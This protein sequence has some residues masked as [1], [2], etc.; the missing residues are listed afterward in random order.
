MVEQFLSFVTE[1]DD[2][3]KTERRLIPLNTFG[4]T[5]SKFAIK[6]GTFEIDENGIIDID[7]VQSHG[8]LTISPD[9]TKVK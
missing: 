5:P 8:K 9:G 4:L 7:F 1:E 2:V 3:L 6:N